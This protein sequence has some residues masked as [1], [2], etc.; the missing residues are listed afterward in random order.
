[1]L[2]PFLIVEASSQ[3]TEH[4]NKLL[5]QCICS[6]EW[7]SDWQ[8]SM[9]V[10]VRWCSCASA[11]QQFCASFISAGFCASSSIMIDLHHPYV[12][13]GRRRYYRILSYQHCCALHVTQTN[14]AL[15]LDKRSQTALLFILTLGILRY[16]QLTSHH[17]QV[18]TPPSEMG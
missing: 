16:Y 14:K 15:Q 9:D 2:W 7:R 13:Q 18:L 1:M 8:R 17:Y 4:G 10:G 12:A 5:T 6:S 3:H 11:M